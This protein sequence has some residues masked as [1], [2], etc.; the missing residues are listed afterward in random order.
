MLFIFGTRPEAIK[1]A[2][3]ILELHK[4]PELFDVRVCITAQHREM[5]DQVLRFFEI[6][7]DKDLNIMKP[8]QTLFDVTIAGLGGLR[9]VIQSVKP[10]WVLVQGDTTTVFTAALASYYCHIKVAHVEAGLRS[11]NKFAPFPEEMNRVMTSR[12][13]DLH[14]CPT[15][16]ARTNLLKE[17]VENE[18]TVVVGNTVIDALLYAVNKVKNMRS[19][20]FDGAFNSIDVRDFAKK[21]ILVTGHRRENFGEPFKNIC[22]ALKKIAA[23][24]DIAIIYPVHLNPNV[25]KPVFG[26]LRGIDNVHLIEPLDYAAFVWLME[27]SHLILTDSGGVQEEAPSLGKPVLVMREVTERAEGVDAGTARLVGTD[28]ARITAEL[29]SLLDDPRHY[30]DMTGKKNPYGDGTSAQKIREVLAKQ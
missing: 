30:A 4:F 12:I 9:N 14:F 8:G 23:R 27:K 22:T 11:F 10:D 3:V 20:D 13:A 7:P 24:D 28:Q 25:R 17:G 19:E 26:I 15:E 6:K 1:L 16:N 21:I 5:L 29:S 18:D 2:P